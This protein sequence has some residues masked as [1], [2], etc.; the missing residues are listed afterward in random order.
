MKPEETLKILKMIGAFYG[1]GK[2]N[3][4]EMAAAWH[5]VFQDYDY[6]IMQ[7]AVINFAKGDDRE[8]ATFPSVGQIIKSYEREKKMPNVIYGSAKARELYC[9]LP[10]RAKELITEEQYDW[11]VARPELFYDDG[12]YEQML[13]VIQKPK[14]ISYESEIGR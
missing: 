13:K 14:E 2:A 7:R 3:P 5:Y 4:K 1:Q 6:L 10:A 8:Y 11:F 9:N 12:C